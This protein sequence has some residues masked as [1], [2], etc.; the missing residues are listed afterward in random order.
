MDSDAVTD[1]FD[2]PLDFEDLA[3]LSDYD[4]TGRRRDRLRYR[5]LSIEMLDE[6]DLRDGF[7]DPPWHLED[8]DRAFWPT[9][10]RQL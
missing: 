7:A 4:R 8:A 9:S 10:R 2:I 5:E 1:A 6:I 3:D